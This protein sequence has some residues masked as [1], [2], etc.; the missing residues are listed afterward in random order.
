[1]RRLLGVSQGASSSSLA[2]RSEA[3]DRLLQFREVMFDGRLE[4]GMRRVEVAMRE[5]I[6]H[7][8][9]LIP[10]NRVLV[11]EECALRPFTASPI[12]MSRTRTAS[13]ISPSLSSPRVRW[14][15]IASIAALMSSSR[16]CS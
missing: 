5:S 15:R 3:V 8:G 2:A 9:D 16:R 13:K 12:S 1:M 6:S 11:G 7:G 4:D 14:L 10:W